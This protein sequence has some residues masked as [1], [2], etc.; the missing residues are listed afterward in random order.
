MNLSLRVAL[1]TLALCAASTAARADLVVR[2]ALDPA[3]SGVDLNNLKIGQAVTFDVVLSGLGV[4]S[5]PA[6]LSALGVD[7]TVLPKALLG[8]PTVPAPGAII[9]DS[10]AFFSASNSGFATG[11]YDTATS[12]LS[13]PIDITTNGVFFTFTARAQAAGSGKLTFTSA[14]GFDDS[15]NPVNV[16][17][18]AT[19]AFKIN[20]ASAV[21]E[22]STLLMALTAAACLAASR[23]RARRAV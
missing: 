16:T 2:F 12:S 4:G 19:L 3:S 21:P 5:S 7:V 6:S 13:T 1:A 10:T 17:D 11:T 9:P 18:T 20:P 14:G 15:N 22:P 23:R 8:T